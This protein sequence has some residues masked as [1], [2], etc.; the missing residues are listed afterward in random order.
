MDRKHGVFVLPAGTESLVMDYT[1]GSLAVE[2]TV[3]TEAPA[4]RTRYVEDSLYV[5]AGDAV[6]VVDETDWETTTTL[7]L[8]G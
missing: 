2:A 8:D 1:D 7:E 6:T 5:F 3:E 4:T